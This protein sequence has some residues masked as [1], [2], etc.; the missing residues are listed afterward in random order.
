[1]LLVSTYEYN[2]VWSYLAT[3]RH[4]LL[5]FF[6]QIAKVIM[7]KP[8]SFYADIEKLQAL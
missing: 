1:M 3:L 5:K 2:F 6:Y 7:Q 8:E 4:L